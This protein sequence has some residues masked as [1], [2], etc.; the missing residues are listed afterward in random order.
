MESSIPGSRPEVLLSSLMPSRQ[1][2]C[3]VTMVV[4][5]QRPESSASSASSAVITFVRLAGARC[6]F[7]L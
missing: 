5:S 2:F 4:S 3:A 1:S 7:S 6:S